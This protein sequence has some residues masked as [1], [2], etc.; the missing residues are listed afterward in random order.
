MTSALAVSGDALERRQKRAVTDVLVA[1][2]LF[3]GCNVAWRYGAGPAIGIVG[4]RVALGAVVAGGIGKRQRAGSWRTPLRIRSGR[5][6]VLISVLGLIAAGTMFRSLDG[7]LAGLAV[8]CVPAVALL[9][10]DRSGPLATAAAL[11]SSLIAIVGLTA[12]AGGVGP[13]S[14]SWAAAASAVIFVGLEVASLRTSEIAVEDGLNPTAIVTASMVVGAIFLFPVSIVMGLLRDPST[15]WSAA[16][17][18]LAVA[19]FGTIGRVL[20]T[21]ALPAAG[22]PAVAASSQVNAL[23]TAIGGVLIVGDDASIPSL[24]CTAMAAV[25]G[26]TAVVSA[27]RWRLRRDPELGDALDVVAAHPDGRIG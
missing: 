21:A 25:L 15:L 23:F 8:A 1:A 13:D 27:T 20:R 14:V 10:R 12:A 11:G 17:A 3:A 7:P 5:T 2:V 24:V 22:V 26:A 18:A 6:A 19:L 16:A 9:V 4:I